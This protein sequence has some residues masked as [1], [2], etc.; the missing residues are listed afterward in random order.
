MKSSIITCNK[1][2]RSIFI[3]VAFSLLIISLWSCKSR[4]QSDLDKPTL[5]SKKETLPTLGCW[6]WSEKEFEPD[7]FQPF[8][9]QVS[10][11]SA[12]NY[13]TTSIRAPKKEVTDNDVH[14]QIKAASQY[15]TDRNIS[16]IMDLD[17]RLARKKFM[18]LYPD[19]LQEMLILKEVELSA[20]T[21]IETTIKSIDLG[22]HYTHQTTNYIALKG[23]VVRIY[24][25]TRDSLGIDA[26]SLKNITDDC[27]ELFISKDSIRIQLPLNT[28]GN[29]RKACI[30]TS[31][32][33]FTPDVFAPHIIDFQH[34]IIK[35]YG[36]TQLA[37]AC[38]D[39]WGF[40]PNFTGNPTK[41]QF[42]FSKHRAEAY[43]KK[44]NGREL[45]ADCLLM[46]LGIKGQENQRNYAINNFME[47]SWQRN[48]A[49]ENAF[50]N[51]VKEVFGPKGI[52]ATHP[53]WW[54]YPD[55]REFK[56]NGLS[57]WVATRDWAQTD[58]MTPFAIRTA[59]AKKW[60][61][62]IW[63]NMF[64]AKNRTPYEESVWSSILAG[65]RIN[66]HRP[67]PT[68]SKEDSR[69]ELLRGDLMKAES[70]VR[71]LNYIS[72]SPIDS[73]V[74]VIFGHAAAMN[75]TNDAY[76][77]VGLEVANRLW[78]RGYPTDLIPSSEIENKNIYIDDEGWVCYGLQRY[79]S[80]ILYNP[81]FEKPSTSVLFNKVKKG[82]TQLYKVGQNTKNFNSEVITS[83][84][85]L[86]E[87]LA[88]SYDVTSV[89]SEVTH[90][91]QSQNISP[92]TPANLKLKGFR[93]TSP[94]PPTTGF[95]RLIDGTLIQVAGSKNVAGD[96]ITSTVN[97]NNHTV[98]FDAIGIAAVRL[99]T[100]GN[101]NTI[102]A[103]GLKHF[104]SGN[105]EIHLKS[106]VDIALWKD[107]SNQWIGVIQGHNGVIPKELLS[108][109]KKWKQLTI[110]KPL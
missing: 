24:A 32:T 31:F 59:L 2:V 19:E 80:V 52:V 11:H 108:I 101:P 20:N 21:P 25:Y 103:A 33:H 50:Y 44:T 28:N 54:P 26:T 45:I 96:T 18:E 77:S 13:L 48:G 78:E 95:C 30:M 89:V 39:E 16:M 46:S 94:A 87:S 36:D 9:D 85:N 86:P 38:K 6:F 93:H 69:T 7:G 3:K 83:E 66:Y 17:V 49:I 97:I 63:Y 76:N 79:S 41:N 74:A 15:A 110:P 60:R 99:D 56:K 53:T 61:S 109:T 51:S 1:A 40:P 81:E 62:P 90:Y 102:S 47:M 70:K 82:T 43:N 64:Y 84:N 107:E 14:D 29:K 4:Y 67:Y 12:Y 42:W 65:G 37:G 58:E 57:W 55:L 100:N 22:D 5:G 92:Q 91:L 8:I 34:E 75:W 104:K 35:Q 72:E 71:L 105:F 27:K 10:T 88:K 73:R 68:E 98:S 106:R 23:S